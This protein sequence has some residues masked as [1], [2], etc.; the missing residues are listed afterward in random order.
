MKRMSLIRI[1]SPFPFNN[2][3]NDIGSNI[4][5]TQYDSQASESMN[6]KFDHHRALKENRY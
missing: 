6:S 2:K 4:N 1:P 3:I 5:L